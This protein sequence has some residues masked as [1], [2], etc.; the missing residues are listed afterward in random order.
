MR[1]LIMH[2]LTQLRQVGVNY[3]SGTGLG[4]LVMQWLGRQTCDQ[5]VV[6]STPGRALLG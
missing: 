1:K 2:T 4:G 3:R 6:S 5:Q